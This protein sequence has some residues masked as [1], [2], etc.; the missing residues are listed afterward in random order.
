M[1][2]KYF[3]VILEQ[4]CTYRSH[5]NANLKKADRRLSSFT[6]YQTASAVDVTLAFF[7]F[8]TSVLWRDSWKLLIINCITV[9]NTLHFILE[10]LTKTGGEL[11]RTL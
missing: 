6:P 9:E 3:E 1:L 11:L 5:I 4:K 7:G 2:L 8:V 10:D